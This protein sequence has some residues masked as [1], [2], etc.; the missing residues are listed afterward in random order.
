MSEPDQNPKAAAP[1]RKAVELDAAD[2]LAAIRPIGAAAQF[3]FWAVCLIVFVLLLYWLKA[4]LLPFVAGLVIAYLLDP[5]ADWL[6]TKGLPRVWA[7]TVIVVVAAL[8]FV[9][10]V[11]L[12]VPLVQSQIVGFIEKLPDYVARARELVEWGVALMRDRIPEADVQRLRDSVGEL[13]NTVSSRIGDLVTGVISG[14]LAVL[15]I[16]SLLVITPIVAFYIILDWDR[17]VAVIDGLLPRDHADVIREQVRKIDRK[18]AGFIRGQAMVAAIQG[19][20]YAVSLTL[21][22]LDFG[23]LIGLGAGFASF[24]PYVGSIGGFVVSVG[25]A[26]FQFSDILPIAIVA[27]IFVIGQVVEGNFLTPK[28]VGGQV[29][30]HPVWMIFALLAGGA[31]LG[32]LGL[33]L[34]VPIAA[35]L[36]VVVAFAI[37]RYRNSRIYLGSGSSGDDDASAATKTDSTNVSS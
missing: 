13:A 12:L 25:V 3:V 32:M 19:V 14:S 16:V 26:V 23:L 11:A 22:G 6:E 8:A 7:T 35:A 20:F 34:A 29:G 17:L 1:Q 28:L 10:A 9:S 33:L 37:E 18:L 36:S 5:V 21:V 15:N 30:L 27:G 31:A 2:A 24:I 4:V